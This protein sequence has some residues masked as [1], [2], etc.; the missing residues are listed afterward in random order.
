MYH[1]LNPYED[2]S[3]LKKLTVCLGE[4]SKKLLKYQRMIITEAWKLSKVW[5]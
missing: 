3:N 4:K 2:D 1:L 5:L